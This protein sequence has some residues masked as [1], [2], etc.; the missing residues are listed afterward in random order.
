[1]D[2]I[3]NL[4]NPVDCCETPNQVQA[5]SPLDTLKR[6]RLQLESKLGEV[7][8]AIAALEANPEIERVLTLLGK[9]IRY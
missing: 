4:T 7:N 9:A 8:E 2:I 6:T 5:P 1:M 3:R